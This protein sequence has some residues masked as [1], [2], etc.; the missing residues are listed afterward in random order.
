MTSKLDD[1]FV[2][3]RNGEK[4]HL[5]FEKINKVLIWATDGINGVSASDIA[6]NADLKIHNGITTKEIHQVL[7]K[8]AAELIS[9]ESPNYQMVA[10]KLVNYLLRKEVFNTYNNFPRLKDL[11]KKNVERGAYDAEILDMYDDKELDKIE[12]F[13]KHNRDENLA[14][15]GIQQ[16]IDKYLVRDR[17]TNEY[18]ETP[19]FMYILISM[20]IYS[21]IEDKK[22]RRRLIK[23]HYDLLS[24]QTISLSTPVIA[25]IRTPN[26][27]FS[28]CTLIDVDD[29]L[30]SISA[31][32]HA[33]L[34]YISNKAG[35]G[36]N[37]RLRGEG[38]SVNN[39]EKVHTG[40]IPF[41]KMFEASVKSCSQGGI[42]GGAATVHY[43]FWH[44]EIEEIISLKNNSGT[45][46]NSARRLDHSIQLSRLFYRRFINDEEITLFHPNETPGLM[47]AFGDNDKFDELY[48]KYERAYKPTTRK[49]KARDLMSHLAKER[50]ETGRIYIQN[51]DNAN[52]H[53]AFLDKIN[54]SNLCLTPD[55]KVKVRFE[56][57]DE[58][59]DIE[60]LK[61]FSPTPDDSYFYGE[62]SME[63]LDSVFSKIYIDSVVINEGDKKVRL[64]NSLTQ[65]EVLSKS[66]DSNKLE[67][68][69]VL[70][71]QMTSEDAEV[72]RIT[73]EESG[74]SIE[75]TADHLV[76]TTNRGYVKAE[77]LSENDTLDI[78]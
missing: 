48:E 51:I 50:V 55:A 53:S 37:M 1:T 18:Y 62:L 17:H 8:S 70:A 42:R 77:D 45:E 36:L 65:L 71:S 12:A 72:Y 56:E 54:M 44:Y 59:Y 23:E 6:M 74:N 25:G 75:C 21:N 76:Y 4:E 58:Q 47:E 3:K 29:D 49:I 69:P 9:E 32:N 31:S 30:E 66:L 26:K 14:Y 16:L 63:E 68:K 40:I 67:Y 2:I 78:L 64:N 73:D 61:T 46:L 34:R 15:A 24:N 22:E 41:V 19:Q 7:I 60:L 28:S 10:S 5:N 38:A 52:T 27:Q 57:F 20:V 39:G 35:I 11:V 13:I 33:V 43:P